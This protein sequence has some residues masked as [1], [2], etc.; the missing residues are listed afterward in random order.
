MA[1]HSDGV[2]PRFEQQG[3]AHPDH[4]IGGSAEYVALWLKG[5]GHEDWFYWYVTACIACSLLVYG[6]M[7]NSR[8]FSELDRDGIV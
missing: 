4:L 1:G 7:K 8:R 2:A 3:L 5:A 6:V